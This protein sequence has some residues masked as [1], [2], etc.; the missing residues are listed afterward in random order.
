MIQKETCMERVIKHVDKM[1]RNRKSRRQ[2]YDILYIILVI[3]FYKLEII[4]K[5]KNKGK[6]EFNY[7]LY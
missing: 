1:L 3:F 6:I 2:V 4:I 7:E 5:N